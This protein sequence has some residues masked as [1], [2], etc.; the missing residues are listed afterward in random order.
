MHWCISEPSGN[1]K[2]QKKL[3]DRSISGQRRVLWS[4]LCPQK[5][6]L[7]QLH[8]GLQ[9]IM[10]HIQ[11]ILPTPPL[12]LSP[13]ML[14]AGAPHDPR[15]DPPAPLEQPLASPTLSP[16]QGGPLPSAV[17]VPWDNQEPLANRNI[18]DWEA[19]E[20]KCFQRAQDKMGFWEIMTSPSLTACKTNC[21]AHLPDPGF[22]L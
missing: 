22:P 3:Y 1:A 9:L 8:G 14:P 18:Q 6:S 5:G 15:S 2:S 19:R 13:H 10:P 17:M 4:L 16:H 11:T 21:K 12:S 20:G 7:A